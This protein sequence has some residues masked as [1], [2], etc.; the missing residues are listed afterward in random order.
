LSALCVAL[1]RPQWGHET[2]ELPRGGADIFVLFDVSNS[3]LVEDM[4][5]SRLEWGRRKV[6]VL[7]DELSRDPIHRMGL[8]PFAGE[9]F[10]QLPPTPDYDAVRFVLEDLNPRSVAFGG[11]DLAAAIDA[12]AD[13]LVRLPGADKAILVISDGDAIDANASGAVRAA[14]ETSR[15]QALEA[16]RDARIK[17]IEAGKRLGIYALGVGGNTMREVAVPDGRGGTSY[18]RYQ[19][20]SGGDQVATSALEESTLAGIAFENKGYV[21]STQDDTDVL[22]LLRSGMTSGGVL[23]DEAGGERS[24]PIERFR[25]PLLLAFVLLFVEM[26]LPE[27]RREVLA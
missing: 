21:H 4:G 2:V 1:A 22:F 6:E 24:I 10:V 9:P 20:G 11:S 18:V 26:F 3:M 14:R 19:E 8:M 12:A 15:K 25:W 13:E 17:A 23:L 7:L 27:G 16:A 5:T